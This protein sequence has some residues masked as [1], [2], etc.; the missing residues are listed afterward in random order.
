MHGEAA[1]HPHVYDQRFAGIEIQE[2]VF[3]PP[4]QNSHLTA[5]KPRGKVPGQRNAQISAS[6]IHADE[7]AARQD[8]HEALTDR[9][10]FRKF[11]HA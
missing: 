4:S 1:G 8:G 11:G 10:D 2:Q 7:A 3:R 6:S 5:G 9:F